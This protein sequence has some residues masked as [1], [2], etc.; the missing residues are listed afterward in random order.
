MNTTATENFVIDKFTAA[1]LLAG[2]SGRRIL[3][4]DIS[5]TDYENF[6]GDF[7]QRP[8]W[9]LAFD[10]GRLEIEPSSFLKA[11]FSVS[12]HN[13]I[14][15]YCDEMDIELE[16]RRS[17]TFR[18]EILE[19]GVEP[20]EC[21]YIQSAKKVAGKMLPT[22]AFPVPDIAVE[23]DITTESLDKFP[24]YAALKVAELWIFNGKD[25]SFY[26]L[27][28]EKYHQ[29]TH[30]RALPE[31]SADDLVKF[32]EISRKKGQTAALK[33]FRAWLGKK[34]K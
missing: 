34:I 16:G 14:R 15:A 4:N 10:E 28:G 27:E 8:G 9:R 24:I 32:L 30:S 33:S 17:A 25:L 18:S 3:L 11:S 31:L 19:K 22:N 20:D 29:I 26:E 7:E 6:L 2:Q 21:Y 13:F 23:V 1:E 5:W 12:F